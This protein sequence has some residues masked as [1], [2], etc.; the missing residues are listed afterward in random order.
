MGKGLGGKDVFDLAGSDAKGQ[1]AERPMCAGVAVAAH[2]SHTGQGQALFGTNDVDDALTGVTHRVVL[3]AELVAVG[4]EGLHLGAADRIGD[5]LVD[6]GRGDIV[7]L[8]G[9]GQL[10]MADPTSGHAE[11]VEGLRRGDLVDQVEVNEQEVGFVGGGPHHVPIPHLLAEGAGLTGGSGR[12][13]TGHRH[14]WC[15]PAGRAVGSDQATG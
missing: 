4:S 2:H 7:V 6:V 8:G 3:H 12:V 1:G 13:G 10:G 9:H 11:A 5:G 14:S 15:A